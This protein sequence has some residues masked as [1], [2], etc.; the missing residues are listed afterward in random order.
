MK[1]DI[2][3]VVVVLE[4]THQEDGFILLKPETLVG[5]MGTVSSIID[6]R[7]VWVAFKK[8]LVVTAHPSPDSDPITDDEW[9]FDPAHIELVFKKS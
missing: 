9:L 7:F 2:D 1:F 5:L 3:D 4:Q 8:G 6:S